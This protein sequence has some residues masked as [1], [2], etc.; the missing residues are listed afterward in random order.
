MNN[1]LSPLL[2]SSGKNHNTQQCLLTMLEKWKN[3]LDTRKLIGVMLIN[4][5]KAFDSINLNFLV[6]KLGAYGFSGITLQFIRRYLKKRKQRVNVNS[7]FSEWESILTGV[8][9]DSF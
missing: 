9:Q 6:V 2:T 7:T 8:L 1:K 4:L 5:S 3:N